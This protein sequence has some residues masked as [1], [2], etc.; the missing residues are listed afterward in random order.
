M[1]GVCSMSAN[2][3][4]F[5]CTTT[6]GNQHSWWFYWRMGR[7]VSH[8]FPVDTVT[9]QPK[10]PKT[11]LNNHNNTSEYKKG[12]SSLCSSFFCSRC[13]AD[14]RCLSEVEVCCSLIITT[15]IVFH[16]SCLFLWKS[17]N[18]C[19]WCQQEGAWAW[20]YC[21]FPSTVTRHMTVGF[22]LHVSLWGLPYNVQHPEAPVRVLHK[23]HWSFPPQLYTLLFLTFT[24][25][26]YWWVTVVYTLVS[27]FILTWCLNNTTVVTLTLQTAVVLSRLLHL[28]HLPPGCWYSRIIYFSLLSQKSPFSCGVIKYYYYYCYRNNNNNNNGLWTFYYRRQKLDGYVS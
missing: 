28:S 18:L 19:F 15:Y 5:I 6:S 27:L 11:Q 4:L 10:T 8:L 12:Q 24:E 7:H 13:C 22:S 26:Y 23:Q 3:L 14:L 9:S 1:W 17:W 25:M 20:S 2:R 16:C 21:R